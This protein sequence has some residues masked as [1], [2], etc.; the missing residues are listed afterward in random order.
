MY[1]TIKGEAKLYKGWISGISSLHRTDECEVESNRTTITVSAH[2]GLKDL[3]LY[4][5]GKLFLFTLNEGALLSL[6]GK[7]THIF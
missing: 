5:R 6:L 2:L 4:Y 7:Q 3:K 1:I